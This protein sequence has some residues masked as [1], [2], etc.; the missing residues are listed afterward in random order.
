M[1]R[2]EVT[3]DQWELVGTQISRKAASVVRRRR[4]P[5]TMF[6]GMIW[7]LRTGYPNAIYRGGLD[8]GKRCT[9]PANCVRRRQWIRADSK[10]ACVWTWKLDTQPI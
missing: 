7:I 6:N 4:D 3:D 10:Q 5:R 1:K 8:R 9:R 2:H